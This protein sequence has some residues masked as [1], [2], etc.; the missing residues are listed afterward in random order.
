[1]PVVHVLK[2]SMLGVLYLLDTEAQGQQ[3]HAQSKLFC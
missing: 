2:S 1:M 3:P